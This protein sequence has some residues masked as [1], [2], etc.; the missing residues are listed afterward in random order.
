VKDGNDVPDVTT[1]QGGDR[2][3]GPHLLCHNLLVTRLLSGSGA[4][5]RGR[6]G[7]ETDQR[8]DLLLPK[9]C[10]GWALR[11]IVSPPIT[12]P[13]TPETK[14]G[15]PSRR[16]AGAGSRG[17]RPPSR[18]Q[19]GEAI[20]CDGRNFLPVGVATQSPVR[21]GR[22]THAVAHGGFDRGDSDGRLLGV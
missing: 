13:P 3:S 14:G 7:R 1:G 6:F 5:V 8:D 12:H 9:G 17:T 18:G 11:L 19:P 4:A 10:P 2:E 16:A 15:V 20:G 21:R 22:L